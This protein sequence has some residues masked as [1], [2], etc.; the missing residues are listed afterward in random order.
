MKLLLASILTAVLACG[1]T[2]SIA[3]EESRT[4]R[5][6]DG[7]IQEFANGSLRR[8]YGSSLVDVSTD[9]MIVA[10]VTKDGRVQ[11]WRDGSLRRSYG[12]GIVRVQVNN[13]IVFATTKD[14]RTQEWRDGSLRRS[15]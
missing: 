2:I 5:I 12:T 3:A 14:G 7:R 11:E 9:G 15:F 13:G 1:S 4:V 8:S 6:R 10:A